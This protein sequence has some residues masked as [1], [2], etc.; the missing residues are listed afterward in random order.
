MVEQTHGHG[1]DSRGRLKQHSRGAEMRPGQFGELSM[2][3]EKHQQSMPKRYTEV[4]KL[5]AGHQ[6]IASDFTASDVMLGLP[7]AL[8]AG[9]HPRW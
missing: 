4:A 6:W 1:A 3:R 2:L 7:G 8:T 5:R 9:A